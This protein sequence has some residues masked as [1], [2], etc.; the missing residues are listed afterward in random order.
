MSRR[1]KYIEIGNWWL[2][3]LGEMGKLEEV[4]FGGYKLF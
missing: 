3:I 4:I 1:D 2:L